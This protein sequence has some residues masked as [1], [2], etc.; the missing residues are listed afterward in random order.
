MALQ[1]L[2]LMVGGDGDAVDLPTTRHGAGARR[3]ETA[4][5]VITIHSVSDPDAFWGGQL[6]LPQGTEL[7]IVAPSDDG[8]R[9]VCVF[10]S[11]SVNTVRDLVDGATSAI[12]RNEYFALNEGSAMGLPV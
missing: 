8:T 9:G 3:R 2:K 10:K 4:M 11:D 5:Y 7:P 6:D 12:S 1:I